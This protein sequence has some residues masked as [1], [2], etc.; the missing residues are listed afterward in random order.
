MPPTVQSGKPQPKHPHTVERRSEL[1][2]GVKYCN[3][4]PDIPFDPKFINYPFEGNRYV[5]YNPTSLERNYKH[6][7]LTEHDLGVTIDL[8][9]PDRY[10][11][12]PGGE[13]DPADERLLEEDS[14]APQDFKRSRHHAKNVSW[15]R[16]TEYIST[17]LT[18]FQPTTMDKIESKVGFS[19]KKQMADN[20]YMDRDSQIAAIEKTFED[21]KKPV[22]KHYSKPGVTAVAEM[23]VFPDFDLWKFPC[24]Q[25]IFDSDPAPQDIPAAEQVEVMS[26]AMIRGV[27]DEFEEQFV[28]YFLPTEET[29]VKRKEDVEAG[30]EYRD[31]MEYD[32]VM[33]REYNW[34]VKNKASKGYEENYFFITRNDKVFYNELETRVRL[35]KRRQKGAAPS[36][37]RLVVRHRPLSSAEFRV[38]RYRERQLEPPGEEPEDDDD[39]DEDDEEEEGLPETAGSGAATPADADASDAGSAKSGRSGSRS[40]AE[41]SGGRSRSKSRSKSRSRSRSSSAGSR[42]SSNASKRSAASGS[43]SGSSSGSARSASPSERE[44]KRRDQ[45]EIF[46]S[47][48]D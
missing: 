14:L 34:N 8:I 37:S 18:R 42:A 45:E 13:L 24:A 48:S 23:P 47:D 41:R 40:P 22:L 33:H 21:V 2:C 16:R 39:D 36:R 27:M 3:T 6:E 4:L 5:A 28:A 1:V 46:G 19:I 7:L 20:M 32:Y 30:D 9:D 29:L 43:S 31:D 25:V 44:Q 38:Q 10:A 26:Q 11:A 12:D 15:L 17:E 35:S